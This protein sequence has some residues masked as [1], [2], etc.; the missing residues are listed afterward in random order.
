M[1]LS[2]YRGIKYGY[3]YEVE[4]GNYLL[5]DNKYITHAYLQGDDA[6]IFRSEIAK[7]DNLK[8]PESKTAL[9]IEN[10]ISLYL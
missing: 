8:D 9:L 6:R 7:I 2:E 10:I 3:C 1:M 4:T 5:F